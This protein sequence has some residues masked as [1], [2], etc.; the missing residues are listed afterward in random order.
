MALTLSESQT[1]V[2]LELNFTQLQ[3]IEALI[4]AA[5]ETHQPLWDS[6]EFNEAELLGQIAAVLME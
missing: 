1:H 3:R 5:I 2:Q 4:N 6:V